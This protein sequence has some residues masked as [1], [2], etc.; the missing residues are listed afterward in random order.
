MKKTAKKRPNPFV[1]GKRMGPA[2]RP[3]EGTAVDRERVGMKEG[4]TAEERFD[5]AQSARKSGPRVI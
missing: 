3:M 4:S 5:E 1:P 2:K